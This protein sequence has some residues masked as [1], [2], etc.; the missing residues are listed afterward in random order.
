MYKLFSPNFF[1]LFFLILLV[2]CGG[3]NSEYNNKRY[4]KSWQSYSSSPEGAVHYWDSRQNPNDYTL[5]TF[6]IIS[7]SFKT[8]YAFVS[9]GKLFF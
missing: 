6:P 4:I 9:D 7:A 1:I 5:T 2:G 3:S 8:G